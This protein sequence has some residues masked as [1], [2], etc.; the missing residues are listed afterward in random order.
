M[1]GEMTKEDVTR[2]EY[3]LHFAIADA[4]GGTVEPFDV[5][6]GPYIDLGPT[7]TG[8]GGK[9]LTLGRQVL[10]IIA[11]DNGSLVAVWNEAEGR[12]SG[13]FN[14]DGPSV[15]SVAVVA[16]RQVTEPAESLYMT[17]PAEPLY[18]NDS[19]R[20]EL[21]EKIVKSG[22]LLETLTNLR[23]IAG[24][25]STAAGYRRGCGLDPAIDRLEQA[26]TVVE[27]MEQTRQDRR[28]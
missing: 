12:T 13:Y 19:V 21:L 16:A 17:E 2:E 1:A 23:W 8:Y 22:G 15:E 5:Y 14:P 27:G 11:A 6:Q 20:Q 4:L 28:P 18:M 26:I 9:G 24:D 3:P 25:M 10:W 7:A